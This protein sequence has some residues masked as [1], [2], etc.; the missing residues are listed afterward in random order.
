MGPILKVNNNVFLCVI[1]TPV[2]P[3]LALFTL[4]LIKRS[5]YSF[6]GI[7]SP[8]PA[9]FGFNENKCPLCIYCREILVKKFP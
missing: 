1:I 5:I 6:S 8:V 9:I 7:N 2:V 4:I 3:K